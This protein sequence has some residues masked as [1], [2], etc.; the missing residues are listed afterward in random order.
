M[1]MEAEWVETRWEQST[2]GQSLYIGG[3]GG[4]LVGV[5]KWSKRT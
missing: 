5:N 4:C 2:S 3:G 1:K